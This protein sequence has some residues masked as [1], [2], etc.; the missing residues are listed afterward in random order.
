[1]CGI[2]G[3]YC[4]DPSLT[5]IYTYYSL[6]SLQHRGQE[7]AGMASFDTGI[8]YRRGMGLVTEVFRGEDLSR[9]RGRVAIG[10]V[11]YSTTGASSLE[12]A[13]PFV[14]RSR[15]G[16]IAIAHNGNLVNYAQLRFELE[17]SGAV[18]TTDSDSEV[19]AQLLSRYLMQHD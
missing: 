18:F 15:A 1:M 14:V 10:H 5:P 19:I 9:L 16:S 7:S 8:T 6:F 11:R 4:S 12:N 3:V 13:Q 17:A 2:V